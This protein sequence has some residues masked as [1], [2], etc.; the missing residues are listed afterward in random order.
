MRVF[1]LTYGTRGELE[2]FVAL[3]R[4]LREAGH[5]AVLAGPAS[6]AALAGEHRVPFAALDDGLAA[7]LRDA[8]TGRRGGPRELT[9]AR[10]LAA[11]RPALRRVLD[12]A[13]EAARAA[14]P[15]VVVHHA[16]P[17]AGHHLAERL[18][19]P[20]ALLTLDPM[21]LPTRAFPNPLYPAPAR[22]PGPLNRLTYEVPR[23]VWRY[24]APTVDR[25]RREV[26][27][28]PRRRGRHDPLLRPGGGTAL[29][30]NAVSEHVVPPPA[31]WPGTVH[32]TGYLMP[33]PPPDWSPPPGLAAFLDAGEPPVCVG[34]G[35]A[36]GRDPAHTGRIVA[37]AVDLVG[38]RAV[39][40]TGWGGIRITPDAPPGR[41][42]VVEQAP[43]AW[44]LP[45][46]RAL[47][48]HGGG[49]T[50]AALTAGTPQVVCPFRGDQPSW[51]QWMHRIG[52][53]P[54]PVPQS[55]LTAHRLAAA[56]RRALGDPGLR[57]RAASLGE[58]IRAEDG[59]AAAVRALE[60]AHRGS[61]DSSLHLR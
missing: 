22:L 61:D 25:W 36:V 10:T 44:L 1:L 53:A 60:A 49:S 39:V 59:P 29:V 15:D 40:V 16:F 2:P 11:G 17:M 32:T 50:T 42:C 52:V 23:L 33:P 4:A 9:V 26:L 6:F 13:W 57:R 14:R 51:S 8:V 45:R 24:T 3:G 5:E 43:Y 48:H 31:D 12:D 20:H 41:L 21:Y 56:L 58:R 7:A 54:P 34:F 28:L 18:G 30:L 38:V 47:V 19:V 35:S 55:R 27:R 46:T 37:E